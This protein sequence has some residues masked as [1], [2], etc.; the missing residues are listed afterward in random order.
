MPV[1]GLN[2]GKKSFRAVELDFK[3]DK[4]IVNNFGSFANP[5]VTTE[6]TSPDDLKLISAAIT[7]FFQK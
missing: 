4:V 5:K 2:I 3:K 6:P 7:Q 1:I